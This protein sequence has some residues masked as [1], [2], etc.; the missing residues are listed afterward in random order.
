[1]TPD[2][3]R[4]FK[5][6]AYSTLWYSLYPFWPSWHRVVRQRIYCVDKN[7]SSALPSR[8]SCSGSR[9]LA[10]W[11]CRRWCWRMK[12]RRWWTGQWG[13]GCRSWQRGAWPVQLHTAIKL[14]RNASNPSQG[15]YQ[16]KLH[17]WH[18]IFHIQF[19]IQ[20]SAVKSTSNLALNWKHCLSPI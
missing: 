16:A 13:G 18:F 2:R 19:N 14:V 5:L 17:I 7:S 1:M 20:L 12:T 10:W 3:K 6:N 4:H 8:L 11:S 9:N 15:F